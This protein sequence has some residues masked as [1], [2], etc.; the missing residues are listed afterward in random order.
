MWH[1]DINM[2]TLIQFKSLALRYKV[3]G[4]ED[5]IPQGVFCRF[6]DCAKSTHGITNHQMGNTPLMWASRNGHLSVVHALMA[7]RTYTDVWVQN[8]V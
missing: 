7:S 5:D 6:Y 1:F 8:K 3:Y 4:A 2:T